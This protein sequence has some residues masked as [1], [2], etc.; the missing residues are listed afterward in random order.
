MALEAL[1]H[2]EIEGLLLG[3]VNGL[4]AMVKNVAVLLNLALGQ[5]RIHAQVIAAIFSGAQSSS[6]WRRGA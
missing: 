4:V 3:A 5:R 1:L 2:R 6:L